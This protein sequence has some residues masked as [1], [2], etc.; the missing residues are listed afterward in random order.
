MGDPHILGLCAVD[1]VAQDPT[2]RQTMRGH[3]PPT[4]FAGPA[5][6]DARDED[7]VAHV[8][9]CD[10]GTGGGDDADALVPQDAARGA[11]ADVPLA[12][13]EVGATEG[14]FGD[15]DDG[16]AGILEG[17]NGSVF[18]S[19]SVG[20]G[21]DEGLHC[22]GNLGVLGRLTLLGRVFGD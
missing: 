2:P 18:E 1:F 12:D 10:G 17:G 4:V 6:R 16:V 3:G 14:G 20:R 7:L 22:F 15:A 8:E 19:D 21:V 9:V 5:G 13:V 11:G